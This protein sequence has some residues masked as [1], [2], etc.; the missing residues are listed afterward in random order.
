MHA[1]PSPQ[2]CTSGS[3]QG[4]Q[5]NSVSL[6]TTM[7]SFP[8]KHIGS[9][10]DPVQYAT[11]VPSFIAFTSQQNDDASQLSIPLI[12]SPTTKHASPTPTA[13]SITGTHFVAFQN[14]PPSSA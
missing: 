3:H 2:S 11:H 4:L 8:G 9:S 13:S 12:P 7:Q 5:K 6:L 14:D 1:C 10:P